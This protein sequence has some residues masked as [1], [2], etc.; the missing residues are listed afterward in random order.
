[1]QAIS[2][3][4]TMFFVLCDYSDLLL[5]QLR[6][7]VQL[8]SLPLLATDAGI[9]FLGEFHSAKASY[10]ALLSSVDWTGKLH[11]CNNFTAKV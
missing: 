5:I 2:G 9:P 4:G 10:D 11:N 8:A 6:T 7:Q 1:M 3:C